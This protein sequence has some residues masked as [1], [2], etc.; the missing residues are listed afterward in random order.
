MPKDFRTILKNIPEDDV[1]N[2]RRSNKKIK[3]NEDIEIRNLLSGDTCDPQMN[4]ELTSIVKKSL[5][6]N[7]Y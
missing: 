5:A 7:V 2:C 3:K 6:R 4:S 1:A